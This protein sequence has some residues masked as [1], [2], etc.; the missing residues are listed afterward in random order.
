MMWSMIIINEI[1]DFEEDRRAG[2]LN[3]VARFGRK[4]GAVLYVLGLIAAY[5]VLLASIVLDWFRS[6]RFWDLRA[7]L[8]RGNRWRS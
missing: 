2:K 4:T 6:L 1:P 8:W 7:C 3:L 5:A